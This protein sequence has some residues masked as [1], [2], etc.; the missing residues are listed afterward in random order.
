MEYK[1]NSPME[2]PDDYAPVIPPDWKV[3]RKV[4][5]IVNK[6]YLCNVLYKYE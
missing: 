3:F 6:T 5:D 2:N 4:D 1:E